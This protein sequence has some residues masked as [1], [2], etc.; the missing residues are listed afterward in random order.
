[1]SHALLSPSA[2]HRWIECPPSVR[3]TE[4]MEDKSSA[5]ADEGTLAHSIAENK[6]KSY[7]GYAMRTLRNYRICGHVHDELIIE[8]PIDTNVSEI[9]EMM[10]RTPP[11]AKGLPLRADGYECNFYKKD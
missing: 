1:M 11:F 5:Y 7:L 8:C 6:L 2:S 4:F 3:L 10:G 9:C